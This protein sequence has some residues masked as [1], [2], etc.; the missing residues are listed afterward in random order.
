MIFFEALQYCINNN[1]IFAAYR[2]P[3][4]DSVR[5]IVQKKP[6]A[7]K[8]KITSRLFLQKGFVISPFIENE[9]NYSY[10]IS[11]DLNYKSTDYSGFSE[12][13]KLPANPFTRAETSEMT[14]S[15]KAFI[16]QVE[17]IKEAIL[18]KKFQKA[19]ISRIKTVQK[20]YKH[21]LT[22][23]FK[24]LIHFYPN[25]FV[26]LF[27]IEGQLWMGATPE[28]LLCSHINELV[29]VSLAGT[30]KFNHEN[31]NLHNW[32]NKEKV[33]QELVSLFIEN[34]LQKLK[35]PYLQKDGPYTKKAGN[36]VHLRTD[37]T[38][39]FHKVNGQLG[40][41]VK[42]LHPTSAVCGFPKKA[43]MEF[44][45]SIEKHNRGYYSGFLGP[46]NLDER[47]QLFVNLRC[48]QVMPDCLILHVGAGITADSI[49]EEE[50]AET[51]IKAE[52]LLSVIHKV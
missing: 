17:E 35:I 6:A 27:N 19:V 46:L 43:S 24:L 14:I 29:T 9:S 37:F 20:E 4:S 15:R 26:Y 12:L 40:K 28:P 1:L 42:E 2:L 22:E 16:I 52:T 41:L 47:L 51:E 30:R 23:I 34:A 39:D 50:W 31:L 45:T 44:I 8:V 5:L 49:P 32:S 38:F 13:E 36:L 7:Q 48:M 10:L 18:E 25:A 21:K 3:H 33:E 11:P